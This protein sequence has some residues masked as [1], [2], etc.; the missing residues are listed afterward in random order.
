MSDPETNQEVDTKAL[1]YAHRLL[2]LR[3]RSTAEIIGKMRGKSYPEETIAR[4]VDCLETSGHLDDEAFAK[5][6]VQGR[7]K[8]YGFRR[9]TLELSD[10][11]IPKELIQSTWGCLKNDVDEESVVRAIALKR[12]R[13]Y[14]GRH[15]LKRK[16][17]VMDY[18]ARRG[19]N[20][21]VIG[22]VIRDL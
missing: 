7:M 8:K 4:I 10:K 9:I 3:P 20:L 1:G 17:L 14:Q 12:V 11:G 13:A 2:K 18:L 22:K 5:A 15:P 16:K 19:F 21:D 6:W